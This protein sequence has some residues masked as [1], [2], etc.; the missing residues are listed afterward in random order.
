M[1]SVITFFPIKGKVS[2]VNSMLTTTEQ[3]VDGGTVNGGYWAVSI[4]SPDLDGSY[5]SNGDAIF[6]F[7]TEGVY[8]EWNGKYFLC[9]RPLKLTTTP[10]LIYDGE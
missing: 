10:I 2:S 7:T 6:F 4:A 5:G 8:C 1:G 9:D 3:I